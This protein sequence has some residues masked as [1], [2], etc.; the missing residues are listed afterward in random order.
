NIPVE[1]IPEETITRLKNYNWPGNIRELE[2]IIE[3]GIIST[4]NKILNIEHLQ[5][6]SDATSADQPSLHDHEKNYILEI[7]EKT[8]W[9]ISGKG[10]AADI[11]DVNHQTLRSKIKKLGIERPSY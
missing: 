7:L 5:T 9:K 8:N 4:R 10:S 6:P 11:L 1:E 3:R 2:N